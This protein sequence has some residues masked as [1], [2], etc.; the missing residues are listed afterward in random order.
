MIGIFFS[1]SVALFII[2]MWAA[3]S[4]MWLIRQVL[5]KA[6]GFIFSPSRSMFVA[7]PVMALFSSTVFAFYAT[8]NLDV[9][10]VERI[11]EFIGSTGS[12][13]CVAQGL[14]SLESNEITYTLLNE[15]KAGCEQLIAK[16]SS[17]ELPW[18]ARGPLPA[19]GYK[20]GL[21]MRGGVSLPIR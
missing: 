21:S 15:L 4:V 3:I 11:N 18:V 12:G 5:S 14:R 16:E 1:I 20:S 8:S 2:F 17:D 19:L 7:L 9:A 6:N 10:S 13:A